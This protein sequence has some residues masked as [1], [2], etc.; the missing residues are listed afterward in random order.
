MTDTSP[1]TEHDVYITRAFAAPRDVVWKFWTQPA[2]IAQWFGPDGFSTPVETID[3]D[4]RVGGRWHLV[5]VEDATQA[6][7]PIDGTIT[8]LID[9]EYIEIAADAESDSGPINDIGLR[10]TFHDHGETTRVTLH[11]GP[12]TEEQRRQTAV[13]WEM[14]FV[15]MDALFTGESK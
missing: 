7:Y 14:S 8:K 11:Q 5:M 10:M 15:T 2:L 1:V 4:L 3:I 9:E 6:T 12:F 13:G